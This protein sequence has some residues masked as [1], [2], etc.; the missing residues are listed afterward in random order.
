MIEIKEH[1]THGVMSRKWCLPLGL[2][3]GMHVCRRLPRFG[4]A[5]LTYCHCPLL[6]GLNAVLATQ[7]PTCVSFESQEAAERVDVTLMEFLQV[8]GRHTDFML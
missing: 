7:L 5:L 2:Y 4:C 6:V 3:V 8:S 1:R